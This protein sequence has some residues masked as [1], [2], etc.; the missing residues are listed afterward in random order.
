MNFLILSHVHHVKKGGR[1]F[2]YGPYVRE[3]NIWTKFFTSVTILAPLSQDREINPIEIAY[4]HNNIRFIPVK[5]INLTSWKGRFQTLVS[6]PGIIAKIISAMRS[7]DHIHLRCPGNMG[8]LGAILQYFFPSK[9]KTAKYAGNWDPESTQPYTYKLQKKLISN[10]G[11]AKKMKVLV[12]GEWP[13][14]SQNIVPFFTF[15]YSE[16]EPQIGFREP[17]SSE[18]KLQLLFVG[19]LVYGKNPLM[20]AE[21]ARI[22]KAQNLNFKLTFCGEGD[23]ME[24]LRQ[25]AKENNLTEEVELCG[26]LQSEALK[27]KYKTSHFLIFLSDSEGWPKVVAESMYFGCLPITTPVSCVPYMLGNGERGD[28]V[29][30][31]PNEVVKRINYYLENPL[32]FDRK[33]KNSKEWS[34]AFTKESF[35]LEIKKLITNV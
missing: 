34:K 33:S 24:P 22:L 7:T 19:A 29:G 17:L 8:L 23:Q 13:H 28:L 12:Y 11:F 21:V 15:S 30:K 14:Q 18:N 3:M 16:N 4:E 25:F 1:F 20:A 31:D 35:E 32:D 27:E 5:E 2:A 26:N 10:P 9:N 6:L